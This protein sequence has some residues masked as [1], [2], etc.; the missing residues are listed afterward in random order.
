MGMFDQL[1]C[2]YPLP[3]PKAVGVLCQT[4]DTPAQYLDNYEIREDG[5]L[6][7][8]AYDVE[9]QSDPKAEGLA[10]LR[11]MLARVRKH[12]EPCRFTGEIVFYAND[13]EYSAYFV[14]GQ[15]KHLEDLTTG[16]Y[17]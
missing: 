14:R 4:K 8:E 6:W 5:S 17:Q 11:G 10:R 1:T 7:H 12:W 16:A 2:R 3:N 9:D 13:F 15:L